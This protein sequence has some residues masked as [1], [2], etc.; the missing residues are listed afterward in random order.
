MKQINVLFFIRKTRALKNG[1]TAINMRIT[2]EGQ[3]TEINTRRT[4]LP[5]QWNQKKEK[6]TGKDPHCVEVNSHLNFLKTQVFKIQQ[7]LEENN[8]PVNPISIKNNLFAEKEKPKLFFDEFENYNEKASESG[9]YAKATIRRYRLCLKYFREMYK[10][11]DSTSK[12][13]ETDLLFQNID[14]DLLFDFQDYL[15]NNKK[16]AH[17]TTIRLL[18][19][20]KKITSYG[21]KKKWIL[22]DPFIDIPFHEQ[23]VIITPLIEEELRILCTRD[24]YITRLNEVRDAFVFCCFTGL[25]FIDVWG[26]KREHI[27]KDN[28]GNLWIRKARKKTDIMCHIPVLDIPLKLIEKYE[29]DPRCIQNNRVLPVMSN[30]KM[31][32]YLK[33]IATICQIDK[34]LTTHV[35]RHTF[36]TTVALANKVS[37]ENVAKMLGHSDLRMTLH[38]AKILDESISNDIKNVSKNFSNL[39]INQNNLLEKVS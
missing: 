34:R 1:E 5:S 9:N 10:E 27:T 28:T 38:Y 39:E 12:K 7:Q 36:A 17:N 14:E 3:N 2:I 19:C 37:L 24:F 18:K 13:P 21:L 11:K 20:V 4:V 16:L 32:A 6:A 25:A 30:Q 23:E 33:E 35:A 8:L 22:I 29:N 26:L 31:N 15:K